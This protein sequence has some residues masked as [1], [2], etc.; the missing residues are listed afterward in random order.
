VLYSVTFR[1][2]NGSPGQNHSVVPDRHKAHSIWVTTTSAVERYN[3]DSETEQ[4]HQHV[5][6]GA[7]DRKLTEEKG[8]MQ[9]RLHNPTQLALLAAVVLSFSLPAAAQ[10]Y[11]QQLT[12]GA[13]SFEY[14]SPINSNFLP[15]SIS[16]STT[17]SQDESC[18]LLTSQPTI[19]ATV[20]AGGTFSLEMDAGAANIGNVVVTD[21]PDPTV[22]GTI[23]SLET[24]GGS[25][26]SYDYIFDEPIDP[27]TYH[28][29]VNWEYQ[30]GG[31]GGSYLVCSSPQTQ[32]TAT[33]VSLT[34]LQ[35]E[36]LECISISPLYCI[37]G[38]SGTATLTISWTA[39][40]FIISSGNQQ[41]GSASQA[42]GSSETVK[43]TD[44]SGNP[45]TDVPVS[46]Q[47]TKQPSGASGAALTTYSTTT[48]P[49][50]TASTGLT[51]GNLSG[52]YQVTAYCNTCNPT[53]S[54]VFTEN[55]IS[56][57]CQA[58]VNAPDAL[59]IQTMPSYALNAAE[60]Q[61]EN[62]YPNTRVLAHFVP[63]GAENP[64]ALADA[65][66]LC[67][68]TGF[69]WQQTITVLPTPSM[70][71]VA[72]ATAPVTLQPAPITTTV[73]SFCAQYQFLCFYEY[74]PTGLLG[75][76][77]LSP[78]TPPFLDPPLNGY[79][80][81]N[82]A[83]FG[84]AYPFYSTTAQASPGGLVVW[85]VINSAL[86]EVPGVSVPLCANTS[87]ELCFSDTPKL[88][89]LN[90]AFQNGCLL[91]PPL[92]ATCFA[93][94]APAAQFTTSLVGVLPGNTPGPVLRSWNW[95]SNFNAPASG[96]ATCLPPLV[97]TCGGSTTA[98]F[99]SPAPGNWTGGITITGVDG[100]TLSPQ[101]STAISITASG[102]AYSRVSQTFDGTLTIT[103]I[104]SG[105]LVGPFQVVFMSM[106]TGV[107]VPNSTGSFVGNPYITVPAVASLTPGQSATVSVEFKNPADAT[108]NLT[109]VI[110]SGSLN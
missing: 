43:V 14:Q 34:G 37:G 102:L 23:L 62:I 74:T 101:P 79:D 66:T 55:A 84:G 82:Q 10:Q 44:G 92:P 15:S 87:L 83:L 89:V 47:I 64:M 75:P 71:E 5:R 70:F 48:G 51:L 96:Q 69:N 9:I 25:S 60:T 85:N 1:T 54:V 110:Y 94:T 33:G 76:A 63:G 26:L 59:V 4:V 27:N 107:T 52:Q 8:S 42:L 29:W 7:T 58:Q 3:F 12:N 106:P 13:F 50:G 39:E 78:L 81:D 72:S 30:G 61:I 105:S 28:F 56:P 90:I 49:S 38:Y 99:S 65:A 98:S 32:F 11:C 17:N 109:P 45:V 67:G 21:P 24:Y 104:S 73:V 86:N 103:N 2:Q 68:F 97:P 16:V 57:S 36:Q 91:S 40:S 46:F 31:R 6:V 80:Y 53:T 77:P 108:I 88:P 41:T 22:F 35:C 19:A 93:P 100:V 95:Q 20:A 18:G